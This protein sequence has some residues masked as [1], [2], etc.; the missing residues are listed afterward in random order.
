MAVAPHVGAPFFGDGDAAMSYTPNHPHGYILKD[1]GEL[2]IYEEY[3]G[4]LFG[5]WVHGNR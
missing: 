4:Y 3:E 2:V 5:R 1:G